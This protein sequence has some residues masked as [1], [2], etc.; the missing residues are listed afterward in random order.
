MNYEIYLHPNEILHYSI[1]K[2]KM[3]S[4]NNY[5]HRIIKFIKLYLT[6][7]LILKEYN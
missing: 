4:P 2:F 5:I 3:L 1:E 6:N 7:M